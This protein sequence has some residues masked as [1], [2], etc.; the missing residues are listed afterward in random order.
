[1]TAGVLTLDAATIGAF[2]VAVS[3]TSFG[4]VM[5]QIVCVTNTGAAGVAS[6]QWHNNSGADDSM[7]TIGTSDADLLAETTDR[8][9]VTADSL[10]DT[11]NEVDSW[12]FAGA[13]AAVAPTSVGMVD[14]H[15]VFG[16]FGDQGFNAVFDLALGMGEK[17][18]LLFFTG[19]EGINADGLALAAAFDDQSSPFFQGL[20][21]DLSTAERASVV[22]FD[23]N[24]SAA[25][26]EPS[27]LALVGCA[28]I[29][30]GGWTLRRR[31]TTSKA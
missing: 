9:V 20:I 14:A 16:E 28:G 5:R 13:G 17:K 22:N 12:V 1:M 10:T 31:R 11:D 21:A 27:S 25:V 7:L 26:P 24:S 19:I 18:S 8:W 6:V 30:T 3:F 15:S 4:P 2:E 23:L 29:V